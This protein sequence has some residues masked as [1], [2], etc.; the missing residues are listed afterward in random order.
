MAPIP[1]EEAPR[2]VAKL[3]QVI[4]IDKR[5]GAVHS[6]QVRHRQPGRLAERAN[7]HEQRH[8]DSRLPLG[9]AEHKPI[10]VSANER[11]TLGTTT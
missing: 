11:K 4:E 6:G 10:Y 9:R 1:K 7:R 3:S 2:E 5:N 8:T